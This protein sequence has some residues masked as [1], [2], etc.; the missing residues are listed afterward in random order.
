[1]AFEHRS[2]PASPAHR[3]CQDGDTNRASRTHVHH[4]SDGPEFPE[5]PLFPN[6]PL[7]Q[8]L[9]NQ[10]PTGRS[11]RLIGCQH[12]P[13]TWQLFSRRK[14]FALDHSHT[15]WFG[16]LNINIL[17]F[18]AILIGIWIEFRKGGLTPLFCFVA[19]KENASAAGWIHRKSNFCE[20]RDGSQESKLKRHE[21]QMTAGPTIGQHHHQ[22]LQ[23]S[24]VTVLPKLL[25]FRP[26]PDTILSW[27]ISTIQKVHGM[28]RLPP[29]P[30]KTNDELGAV[31]ANSLTTSILP[32]MIFLKDS[33]SPSKPP[34]ILGAFAQAIRKAQFSQNTYTQL[35]EGTVK[36]T[37][38]HVASTFQD[39][40]Q[41]DP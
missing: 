27:V 18:L 19:M 14:G 24:V 36:A 6:R 11:R 10:G 31:E 8:S 34:I 37:I 2:D 26:I 41:R 5:S 39:F 12:Q 7:P 29:P 33:T 21:A 35:V 22:C 3:P 40:S 15:P 28:T 13:W 23:L 38:N 4:T 30:P 17:E 9:P 32:A 16:L 1:M 20:S 25:D